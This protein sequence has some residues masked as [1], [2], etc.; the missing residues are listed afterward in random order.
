MDDDDF[1]E[2]IEIE[3]V[4]AND[5]HDDVKPKLDDV[6]V[7]QLSEKLRNELMHCE[8]YWQRKSTFLTTE[9]GGKIPVI[10]LKVTFFSV[11][12]YLN[13]YCLAFGT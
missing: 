5:K 4:S 13:I 1:C 12:S 11:C 9:V 8:S 3:D 7:D 2:I 6:E 10:R